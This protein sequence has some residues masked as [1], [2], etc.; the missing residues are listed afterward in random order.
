MY[1]ENFISVMTKKGFEMNRCYFWL[2]GYRTVQRYRLDNFLCYAHSVGSCWLFSDFFRREGGLDR[3]FFLPWNENPLGLL[4]A[5]YCTDK[6]D[7]NRLR[8]LTFSLQYS[9]N[10]VHN[11]I[12]YIS[13]SNAHQFQCWSGSSFLPLCGSG[14]LPDFAAVFRICIGFNA[15]PE[16]AF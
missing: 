11:C 5:E 1:C 12:L 10:L 3:R 4:L 9:S 16:P 14:S 15:D 7:T 13:V 6:H 8:A 2:S